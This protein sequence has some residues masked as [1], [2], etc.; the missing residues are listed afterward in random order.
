MASSSRPILV[1]INKGEGGKTKKDETICP[2]FHLHLA[3]PV[4][5]SSLN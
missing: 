1:C 3:D 4:F 5:K 2:T